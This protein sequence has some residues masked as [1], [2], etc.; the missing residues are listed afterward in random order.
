MRSKKTPNS[1]RL[2]WYSLLHDGRSTA[3]TERSVYLFLSWPLD[4]LG[5]SMWAESFSFLC[6][7]VS[8]V[9]SS[10]KAY[11]LAMVKIASDI[12]R[13]FM[14]RFQNRTESLSP[15][16]KNM[17]IDLSSTSR[18]IFLLLQKHEMDS[19]RDS[20]FFW[21]TLARPQLTL[22]RAHVAQKL[23]VNS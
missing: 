9:V 1:P 6:S 22:R 21:M 15:F 16:I 3:L 8:R 17:T 19:W 10:A 12:L 7:L 18:I 4:V 11:L 14:V 13:F 5:W 23:L 20:P 2:G